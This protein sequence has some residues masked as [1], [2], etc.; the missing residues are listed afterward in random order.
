MSE[1]STETASAEKK[2]TFISLRVKLLIGFTLIFTI[3]F[4]V[5]FFWFY[6]FATEQAMNRI[7]RD[8]TDTLQAAAK[9]TNVEELMALYRE[10]KPNAD[11]FTDDPRYLDQLNWLQTVHNIEPRAWPYNYIK[12]DDATPVI[13]IADLWY[14]YDKSKAVKFME[15]KTSKG[16][17]YQGFSGLH[18]RQGYPF[19]ETLGDWCTGSFGTAFP[20]WCDDYDTFPVAS[21][22]GKGFYTYRD[23]WGRWVSAYAPVY[24]AGGTAVAA[25]GVD[26]EAN[27][28]DDVQKA[29]GDKVFIAFAITYASLFALIY[30][31]SR[32]LTRPIS[33]LTVTAMAIGEG[34]YEQDL[35]G[36][37]RQRFPD[38]IDTLAQVFQIM[39]DKVYQREQ[40]LRRQV[41]ELQIMVD[42]TKKKQQ[43]DEIADSDFFRDLQAK[44]KKLRAGRKTKGG[45]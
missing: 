44:A 7:Q 21:I 43:V 1:H 30:L 4:A 27:Y 25:V 18:L 22:T 10:G 28:V 31:F 24:D 8:L 9:G 42:E 14:R 5:A 2:R 19:E 45:G 38:E 33:S 6:S 16:Q 12:G 32:A 35:S 3:V 39:V 36:L 15:P 29:I 23:Q 11:G 34:D 26:F 41:Q 13:Y 37:L 20:D 40:T 17:S